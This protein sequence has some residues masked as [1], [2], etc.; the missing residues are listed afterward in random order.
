[1]VDKNPKYKSKSIVL[2]HTYTVRELLHY[3]IAYSDNNATSLLFANMDLNQFKKVFTDV[4]LTAPDLKAPNYPMSAREFT[5]FMRL[6]YNASYL[7]NKN[8]EFATELLSQCNFKDGIIASLPSATKVAHKFGESG[9]QFDQ[10]LSESAIIYL[11][12]N[13]YV[14]TIMT[15][16]KD[17]KQL[18]TVVKEISGIAYQNMSQQ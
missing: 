16:G 9:T 11:D 2:G 4:G 8:S 14:I 5:Y 15:R 7:S 10:E 13:P 3:M 6:L 18:P 1:V 17:Y 12:N